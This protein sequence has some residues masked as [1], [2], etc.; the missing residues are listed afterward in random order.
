MEKAEEYM[1]QYLGFQ[2][3][4][5][6]QI[7]AMVILLYHAFGP[8]HEYNCSPDSI[9]YQHL[10]DDGMK[11]YKL[12]FDNN[13]KEQVELFFF[14]DLIQNLWPSILPLLSFELCFKANGPK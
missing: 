11:L 9:I 13:S 14:D 7:A 12:I 8:T 6:F 1:T 5:D 3:P 4:S 2:E 10:G